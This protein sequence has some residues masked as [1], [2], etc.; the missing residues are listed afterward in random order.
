[1]IDKVVLKVYEPQ[2]IADEKIQGE[3]PSARYREEMF[4]VAAKLIRTNLS[5]AN[6][7]KYSQKDI[8]KWLERTDSNFDG[9]IRQEEIV[10]SGGDIFDLAKLDKNF[11]SKLKEYI[12]VHR[13]TIDKQTKNSKKRKK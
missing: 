1:M 13:E 2:N 7:K 5:P 6:K 8:Y 12:D 3:D 4:N 11:E 10:A 9:Q